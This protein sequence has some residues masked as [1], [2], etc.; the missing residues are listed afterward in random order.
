MLD[1]QEGALIFF[2]AGREN[3]ALKD[4][5]GAA[6]ARVMAGNQILNGPDVFA[7]EAEIAAVAGRT[8]GIAVNSAT[9][10]LFLAM[11][12]LG[13]GPGDEVLVPAFGFVASGA[14][15]VRTGARAV[16]VDV[17]APRG[18]G[19]VCTLNL[20]D[21]ERRVTTST[22]AILWVG[23]FGAV[24]DPAPITEFA[25]NHG[26]LLL[27][28][29]AQGF[30]ASLGGHKAGQLG[31]AAVF[32][33]DRNKVLG[34]PGTGGMVVTDDA[35]L[36]AAV[37]SLRYHGI[38]RGAYARPG[39]N[40]QMSSVTAAVLSIK[41]AHHKDWMA[42]RQRIATAYDGAVPGEPLSWAAGLNH[43]RHKYVLL[44]DQRDALEAHL[45]AH[46]VPTRKH[47]ATPVH[48][49]PAFG[50]KTHLPVAEDLTR[51]A[52]SLPIFAQITEAELDRVIRALESFKA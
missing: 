34:A 3:I 6:F 9:D 16:F 48:Q 42:A 49:E 29:A 33:F 26:L 45:S 11:T 20:E 25:G 19:A 22:K 10:A 4:E 38:D 36:D 27:E 40:S 52:L 50:S 30:G 24:S 1:A 17:H 28:D 8:Y 41:L 15:V 5:L 37:R 12:A 35:E 51:R 32:S 46:G 43:A 21:A 13:I 2:G 7:L 44:T 47:Y 39:Y 14:A 31:I 23:M 18:S